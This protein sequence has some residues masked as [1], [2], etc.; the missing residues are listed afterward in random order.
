M[1]ALRQ[2]GFDVDVYEQTPELT[3]VSGG[4]NMAPNAARVI[5]RLGLGHCGP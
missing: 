1:R 3:A 4:I 2:A 5:H